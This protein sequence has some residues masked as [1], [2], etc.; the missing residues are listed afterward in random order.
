[1]QNEKVPDPIPDYKYEWARPDQDYYYSDIVKT[2]SDV[3]KNRNLLVFNNLYDQ[4]R[5]DIWECLGFHFG[6]MTGAFERDGNY[7]HDFSNR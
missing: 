1:M 2:Y 5:L 7:R 4:Q 6:H 3:F